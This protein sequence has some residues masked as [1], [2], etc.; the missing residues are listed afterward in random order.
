MHKV[1]VMLDPPNCLIC[2][3]GNVVDTPMVEDEFWAIDTERDVNWGDNAYIC[4][5][6]CEKIAELSGYVDA[7]Q[8]KK[9]EAL[10]SKK[11]KEVHD[12]EAKLEIKERRLDQLVTGLEVRKKEITER[13]KKSKPKKKAAA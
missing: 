7:E 12:L 10:I 5:A 1:K 3:R 11:N 4:F 13:K 2:G 6:C 9:L 8:V